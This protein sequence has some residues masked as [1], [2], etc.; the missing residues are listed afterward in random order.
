MSCQIKVGVSLPV[1]KD[2][3]AVFFLEFVGV[4]RL[5]GEVVRLQRVED[6]AQSMSKKNVS[7]SERM[8]MLSEKLGRKE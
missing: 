7:W 1:K 4:S 2:C 8:E 3:A 6:D 5:A